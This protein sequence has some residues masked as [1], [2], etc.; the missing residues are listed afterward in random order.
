MT[1]RMVET[2][3][4]G[5]SVTYIGN[6]IHNAMYSAEYLGPLVTQLVVDDMLPFDDPP[7]VFVL[8]FDG[9]FV[10]IYCLSIPT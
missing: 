5:L 3:G 8:Q 4:C 9:L 1:V 7:S 10:Y 2:A 6:R